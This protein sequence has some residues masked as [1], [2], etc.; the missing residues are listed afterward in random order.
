M[1]FTC[2]WE[3]NCGVGAITICNFN[4]IGFFPL[5]YEGPELENVNVELHSD[6]NSMSMALRLHKDV[7]QIMFSQ[8]GSAKIL[9]LDSETI[10]L[11]LY[12]SIEAL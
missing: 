5:T 4:A 6:I 8:L 2:I 12:S 3:Q 9:S 11:T 10:Q 1:Y 7:F